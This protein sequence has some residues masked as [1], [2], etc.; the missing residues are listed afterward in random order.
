MRKIHLLAIIVIAVAIGVIISTTGDAS[1]YVCFAEAEK[2]AS[3]GDDDKIHVVGQVKKQGDQILGM[4]YHP[5]VDPNYFSFVLVDD[6][7]A[8]RRVVY[9]NPKPQDFERS[10]KIVV[11]GA[12]K[13]E[14]FVADKILM[15]CPSKYQDE[16]FR[17][18]NPSA[19]AK[20]Q[21]LVSQP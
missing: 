7:L 20:A 21:A 17:E 1:T 9:F 18:A 11:V 5:E 12:M 8:E 19:D 10:E 4:T 15:K 14:E 16:E 3:E 13:G 6:S 2:M